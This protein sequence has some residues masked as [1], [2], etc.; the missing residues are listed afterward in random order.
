MEELFLEEEFKAD[1]GNPK[2]E[3]VPRHGKPR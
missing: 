3:D 2:I 1:E